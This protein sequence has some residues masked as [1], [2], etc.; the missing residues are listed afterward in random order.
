MPTIIALLLLCLS[1]A[2]VKAQAAAPSSAAEAVR[3]AEVPQR[4]SAEVIS[5]SSQRTEDAERPEFAQRGSAG[6]RIFDRAFWRS[7]LAGVIASV[8]TAVILRL[9]L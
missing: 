6:E 2:S 9:I 1:T 3:A 5:G 8:L 4:G 7:V